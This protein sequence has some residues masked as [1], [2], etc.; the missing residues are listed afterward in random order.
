MLEELL[1]TVVVFGSC[2]LLVDQIR[3]LIAHVSLN[4]TL[5]EALKQ[6]P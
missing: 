2:V 1:I 5:C 6:A 3:R 4:R